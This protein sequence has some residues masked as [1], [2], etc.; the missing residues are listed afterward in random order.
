MFPTLNFKKL[1]VK[2][3]TETA[4]IEGLSECPQCRRLFCSS[5]RVPR[6]AYVKDYPLSEKLSNEPWF[7]V[8]SLAL[9]KERQLSGGHF[10]LQYTRSFWDTF[11]KKY[12]THTNVVPEA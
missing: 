5:E 6:L 8:L 9:E 12:K 1:R 4:S 10:C 11:N 3:P 2:N 7:R